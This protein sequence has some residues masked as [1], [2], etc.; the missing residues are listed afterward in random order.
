MSAGFFIVF[1]RTAG[2]ASGSTKGHLDLIRAALTLKFENIA[3]LVL[4]IGAGN[5]G[6]IINMTDIDRKQGH[7][8]RL[9][10][11]MSR[12]FWSSRL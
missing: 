9:I 8:F 2:G 5:F 3:N 4:G 6:G 7:V 12:F 11:R 10:L 1:R